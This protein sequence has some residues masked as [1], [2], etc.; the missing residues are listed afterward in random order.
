MQEGDLLR[1]YLIVSGIASLFGELAIAIAWSRLVLLGE[2]PRATFSMPA[3]S[4]RYFSRSLI[5]W[6]G[7]VVLAIPGVIAAGIVGRLGSGTASSVLAG[8]LIVVGVLAAAYICVRVWLVFPAI[9]IGDDD[10]NFYRSFALA[11]GLV[12]PIVVGTL[13]SYLSF[14]VVFLAVVGGIDILAD[15]YLSG[16]AYVCAA[17][18]SEF[19]SSFFIYAAIAASATVMARIYAHALSD[20]RVHAS[21]ATALA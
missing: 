2:P 17:L 7:C 8:T 15:L 14:T 9:A 12:R 20:P 4:A 19:I 13:I 21:Q 5:L 1:T 11:K 16:P 18:L 10:M 3:G 6:F